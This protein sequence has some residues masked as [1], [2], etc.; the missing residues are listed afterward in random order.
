MYQPAFKIDRPGPIPR[1]YAMKEL[2]R[3]HST[4]PLD[5][6]LAQTA[7]HHQSFTWLTLGIVSKQSPFGQGT[8][9]GFAKQELRLA[10]PDEVRAAL[11]RNHP[12][13][14][15]GSFKP[16][17]RNPTLYGLFTLMGNG[18][19]RVLRAR[20]KQLMFR[21]HRITAQQTAAILGSLG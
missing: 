11:S 5:A 19:Q 10:T 12:H 14:R 3:D 20:Y 13:K 15:D 4:L 17:G 16:G 9:L 21:W 2:S 18:D 7:V 6:V 1:F 8:Y